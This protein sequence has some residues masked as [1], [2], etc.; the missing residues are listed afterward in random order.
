MIRISTLLLSLVLTSAG[1]AQV[2]GPAVRRAREMVALINSGTPAMIQAYVDSA[3]APA[4]RRMPLSAHV[5]YVMGQRELSRRLEWVAPIESTPTM[6][7]VHLTRQLTGAPLALMVRTEGERG[8][9]EGIGQRPPPPG[10][11]PPVKASTDREMA[12]EL[13]RYVDVLAKADVFS[14][15]VLLAHN[16]RVL[17]SRAYGQANKDFEAPNQV[18]TR[19]NLGSMNK[20]F[21]GVAIAQLVEKGKLSFDDP[22]SKFL[23][24]YP[25]PEAAQKIRIKHLLTHT[26]GLGSYFNQEFMRS[27]RALYRTVDEMMQLAKGDSMAFEPGTRWAYSNTGMLVLGKVIEV[28][29]GQDYFSYV[30]D[31]I[32]RPAGMTHSDAYELD[33]V[34]PN[35]AVGYD[36]EF[37]PDGSK[38]Y[39][40]NIFQH[41]IRGGPAGGGYSTV[42]DLHRFAEALTSGKLVGK[43]YLEA[44][45][46]PKSEISSPQ[47]GYGFSVNAST[48]AVGHSGGFPGIS[49]NLDIFTRSG[50]VAVVQS[51]YGGGSQ[52][53]VEKM[54]ALVEARTRAV[55]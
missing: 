26:S 19:F 7:V 34:T 14:G 4:M 10:S 6:A 45:T 17:F 42:A 16:G 3:F 29:S 32:Y 22:L 54:R 41:V 15:A 37:L 46:T 50:Y 1:S 39:R 33:Y 2:D 20:M 51:T 38:R 9:I 44:L 40:N 24:D 43:P 12:A 35:L 21:T 23:P 13:E 49:S 52:P 53:V 55:P 25:T 47:Y 28:A 8:L 48:G 36:K 31:N 27:S 5:S 11:A 18:D 30:R